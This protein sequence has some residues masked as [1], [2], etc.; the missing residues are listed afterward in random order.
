MGDLLL[1]AGATA[2]CPHAGPLQIVPGQAKVLLG[3][4]PAATV[5][6]QFTITGC[7]FT[8]PV[9]KPQPCVTATFAPAVKVLLSG[10]PAVL[11]GGGIVCQSAE[12]IPQG[13]PSVTATQMQV[14]GT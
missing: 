5:S 7:P 1:N 9:P 4:Q 3:G 13:P 12:Q 8:T 14:T 6:D 10:T 11:K 2:M